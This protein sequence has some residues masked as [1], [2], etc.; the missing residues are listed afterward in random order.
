[1][2]NVLGK[3]PRG[4]VAPFRDDIPASQL[5]KTSQVDS[6]TSRMA[7]AEVGTVPVDICEKTQNFDSP[8][9]KKLFTG[10]QPRV[11]FPKS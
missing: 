8:Q 2:D 1:M 9:A 4:L 6:F 10:A 11:I 3:L 5:T 7:E